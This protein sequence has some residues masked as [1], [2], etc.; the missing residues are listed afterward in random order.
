MACLS[1]GNSG[2]GAALCKQLAT[3]DGCFVFLGSRSV[4]RGEKALSEMGAGVEAKVTVVQCDISSPESVAA[5]AAT[6]K[7]KLEAP[8]FAL[9]NNAGVG[10][11]HGV[12]ADEQ[13]ATN[14]VRLMT[15][16]PMP[17]TPHCVSHCAVWHQ[18][19]D[20]RVPPSLGFRVWS[21]R[22]GFLRCRPDVAGEAG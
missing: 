12:S 22:D 15:P 8:L 17:P 19:H 10:L 6:V 11:A 3:E 4:E 1:G 20:G 14:L 5:A 18:V 2:I 21:G 16:H 13:I 7:A 9:V